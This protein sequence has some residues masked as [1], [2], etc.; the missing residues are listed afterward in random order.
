MNGGSE[1]NALHFLSF[2][3]RFINCCRQSLRVISTRDVLYYG[4]TPVISAMAISSAGG[5]ILDFAV[6]RFTGIVVFHPVINGVGGNLVAVQSYLNQRSVPGIL[7]CEDGML[8]VSLL[9]TFC[10]PHVHA[11]TARVLFVHRNYWSFR[12]NAI[13]YLQPVIV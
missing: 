3:L 10:G 9:T 13:R 5:M 8:C 11:K 6:S 12:C 4:W 2:D 1:Q 7:T